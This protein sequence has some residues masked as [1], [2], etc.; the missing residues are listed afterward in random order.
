MSARFLL[1][2][3]GV[4]LRRHRLAAVASVTTTALCLLILGGFALAAMMLHRFSAGLLDR[5]SLVAYVSRSVP[6]EAS[7]RLSEE[8]SGIAG[9][10]GARLVNREAAWV[11]EKRKYAHLPE[12]DSM[13]NPLGDEIHLTLVVPEEGR[14]VAKRIGGLAGI[15]AVKAGGDVVERLALLK[16]AIQAAGLAVSGALL[17]AA[18]LI[19]GNAI[20]LGVFSRRREIRIMRLVGATDGFIRFPFLLEGLL[21]GV[22]GGLLACG[23]LAFSLQPVGAFFMNAL[24]FLPLSP[25]GLRLE[26]VFGILMATGVS[27]GLMGSYLSVRRFLRAAE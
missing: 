16:R 23:I 11:E 17:V 25:N 13:E 7:R 19:I 26:G 3:T 27:L 24:P 8:A 12:L 14:A 10:K 21:H 9:V 5:S 2:E 6:P 22:A 20:R 1:R 4:N 18:A 15:E